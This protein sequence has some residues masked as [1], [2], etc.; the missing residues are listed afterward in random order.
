MEAREAVYKKYKRA[1]NVI[2]CVGNALFA[3]TV[4]AAVS[5]VT[6]MS[7]IA[8][9]PVASRLKASRLFLAL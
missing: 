5:G 1:V 7:A 9:L 6:L 2:D 4:A 3:V 8:A